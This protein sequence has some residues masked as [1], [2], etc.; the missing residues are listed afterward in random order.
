M[1]KP[2]YFKNKH[3]SSDCKDCYFRAHSKD[4]IKVEVLKIHSKGGWLLMPSI[5]WISN[6]FE[7][8][9][10][11]DPRYLQDIYSRTYDGSLIFKGYRRV[12]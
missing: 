9:V 10:R 5:E 8:H 1:K 6:F 3:E 11:P 7:E 4:W 2:T 12:A